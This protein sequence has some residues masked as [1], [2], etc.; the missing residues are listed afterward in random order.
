[1]EDGGG[2]D[3]LRGRCG[4]AGG[5]FLPDTVS[6]DEHGQ[7]SKVQA[8]HASM[9]EGLVSTV[10]AVCMISAVYMIRAACTYV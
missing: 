7:R 6:S 2:N 4:L 5:V 9:N 3:G 8:L 10:R 1:M